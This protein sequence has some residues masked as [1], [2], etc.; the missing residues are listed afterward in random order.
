MRE[1]GIDLEQT[2]H[3]SKSLID[4]FFDKQVYVGYLIT[5]CRGAEARCPIY[6]WAG[7]REFWDLEDPAA[8][9][10]TDEEKLQFFR[11]TRDNIRQRVLDFLE[12]L[13]NQEQV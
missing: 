4:E 5:V 3:R 10:G 1:I 11:E 7:V 9:Q 2:N 12:R 8:F 6:P 13:G